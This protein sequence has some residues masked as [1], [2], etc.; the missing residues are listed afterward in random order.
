MTCSRR[1]RRDWSDGVPSEL[2]GVVLLHLHFLADCVY[3]A[4]V[5]R[6]WRSAARGGLAA[7]PRQL[8]WL[9]LP[10]PGV[11]T[12][13]ALESGATRRLYLP[14][15]ICDA[16]LCGSHGGGWVTVAADA[17]GGHAAVDLLSGARVPLPDRLKIR[18]GAAT[19]CMYSLLLRT[20]VF[21]AAPASEGCLAAAHVSCATN[22]AFWRPGTNAHWTAWPDVVEGLEDIIYHKSEV[23]QGFHV[24]TS[25]EDFMVYSPTTGGG[26]PLEMSSGS[27]HVKRRMNYF[28]DLLQG[29]QSVVTCYLVE[30]RGKLL[31]VLRYYSRW[32]RVVRRT[33]KFR[34]FEMNLVIAPNNGVPRASWGD[35]RAVWSGI[36]SR[37]RLL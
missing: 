2:L 10:S 14:E 4:A 6:A 27:Y 8:P 31:M 5:C 30:S 37:P 3:F 7:L 26:G 16:R 36:L 33:I 34:I 21:S 17:W 15:S 1:S 20:V 23:H 12:Y 22:L 28:G 29:R 11:S 18:L 25:K 32:R 35:R 19:T 13:L 9:L 24:L